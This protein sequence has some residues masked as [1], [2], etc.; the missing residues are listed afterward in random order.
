[1][2]S[3][4]IAGIRLINY[5]E[6]SINWKDHK[7]LVLDFW[8]QFKCSESGYR[9]KQFKNMYYVN[10]LPTDAQERYEEWFNEYD[11]MNDDKEWLAFID[12]TLNIFYRTSDPTLLDDETWYVL[13][14]KSETRA[15]DICEQQLFHGNPNI[16]SFWQIDTNSKYEEVGG[17][18]NGYLFTSELKN[19]NQQDTRG[20]YWA[21]AF[22]CIESVKL[23][24]VDG[25]DTRSKCINWAADCD[26]MTLLKV[27]P[28]GRFVV[29]PV[30]VEGKAWRD[31]RTIPDGK[32]PQKAYTGYALNEYFKTNFY[33]MY[34]RWDEI[35]EAKKYVR[36]ASNQ[37]LNAMNTMND[38]EVKVSE[39]LEMPVTEFIA[40][41][42]VSK[43]RRERNKASR[44]AIKERNQLREREIKKKM[45]ELDKA[46]NKS[47]RKERNKL[48][49]FISKK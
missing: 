47:D 28:S 30:F 48:N 12:G 18:R 38:E 23:H 29:D 7:D 14:M 46:S 4:K 27:T 33:E 39:V 8:V 15:R 9:T 35:D 11:F 3:V 36:E 34:G 22:Q 24:Y 10:E 44:Q 41:G 16:D 45:R 31:D 19:V 20:F 49:P 40:T 42:N 25:K 17:R 37:R 26:H 43:E 5:I 13:L 6:D 32:A 1:M 21:V 2:K